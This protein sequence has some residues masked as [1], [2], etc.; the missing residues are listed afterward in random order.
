[1]PASGAGG[2]SGS[3]GDGKTVFKASVTCSRT[4]FMMS[5]LPKGGLAEAVAE[6]ANGSV[7]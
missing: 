4:I 5:S 1:M 7:D 3:G 2:P 6:D